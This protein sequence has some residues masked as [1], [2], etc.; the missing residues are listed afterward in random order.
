MLKSVFPVM[1]TLK[2]LLRLSIELTTDIKNLLKWL[3]PMYL[4]SSVA[5]SN[6]IHSTSSKLAPFHL[7]QVDRD[8]A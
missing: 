8:I 7:I 6:Q 5:S 1:I 4:C 3:I 2:S